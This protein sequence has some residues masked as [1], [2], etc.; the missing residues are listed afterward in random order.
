MD[1]IQIVD[2][3]ISHKTYII[4]RIKGKLGCLIFIN[5]I[6]KIIV[7]IKNRAMSCEITIANCLFFFIL[8][9]ILKN[10]F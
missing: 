2:K 9:I 1:K 7:G 8:I 5:K 6:T 3:M 4:E 10:T